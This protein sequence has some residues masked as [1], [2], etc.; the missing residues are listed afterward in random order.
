MKHV[1]ETSDQTCP[2]CR[3]SIDRVAVVCPKCHAVKGYKLRDG[4]HSKAYVLA[5][6]VSLGAVSI[7]LSVIM[8]LVSPGEVLSWIMFCAIAVCAI[9]G[10]FLF[11]YASGEPRWYR[12][13]L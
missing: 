5:Y 9:S 8:F 6:S 2:F 12:K 4:M 7:I 13:T 3:T 10:I 11:R 1:T